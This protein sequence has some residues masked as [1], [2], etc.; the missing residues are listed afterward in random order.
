MALVNRPRTNAVPAKA[1]IQG[2][3]NR[4]A[5]AKGTKP[6]F[7]LKFKDADGSIKRITGLFAS[8][9]KAGE[10][11]LSGKDRDSGVTYYV[12]TNNLSDSQQGE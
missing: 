4:A 2:Q 7:V 1:P 11:Y 5:T 12:M 3:S 6:G 8:V 10:E 9:S